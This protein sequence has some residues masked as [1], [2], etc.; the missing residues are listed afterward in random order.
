VPTLV[1]TGAQDIL[2]PVENSRRIAERI[3]GARLALIEGG[4]HIF[5][6]EQA[7]AVARELIAHF[8]AASGAAKSRAR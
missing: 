7:D 4:G 3:P 1:I 2:V 6:L 8:E 5:F